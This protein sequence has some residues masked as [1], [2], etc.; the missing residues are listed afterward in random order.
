MIKCL[1]RL[2]L[3]LLTATVLS[4]NSAASPAAEV[5]VNSPE[6]MEIISRA[7]QYLSALT[8]A[9]F[10]FNQS[11]PIKGLGNLQGEDVSGVFYLS[12]P[13]RMR[14]DYDPPSP[15]TMIAEGGKLLYIDRDLDQVSELPVDTNLLGI[16]VRSQVRFSG[17][18]V[19]KAIDQTDEGV[20]I[21]LIQ[22]ANPELGEVRLQ[23]VQRPHFEWLGWTII[24]AQ[25]RLTKVKLS[26]G[27]FGLA[28]NNSIYK[29]KFKPKTRQK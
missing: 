7:E 20:T 14:F 4:L 1:H 2:V 8:T 10:K 15:I 21:S 13:G 25:L 22:A 9:K 3:V 16:F 27:Q 24:D 26:Q 11:S 29:F 19:V 28:I 17:D 6:G 5:Q 23:F 18:I 12:R